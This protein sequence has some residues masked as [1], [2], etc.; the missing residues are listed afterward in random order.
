MAQTIAS[1]ENV[2]SVQDWLNIANT[3]S[4]GS[5]WAGTLY[6][7]VG[8]LFMVIFPV[9]G[10]EGGIMTAVFIGIMIGTFMLYLGII[11]PWI[12]GVLIGIEIIMIIYAVFSSPKSNYQ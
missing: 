5:F 6:L 11:S 7:I 1:W 3:N 10:V 2:T 8:V 12:L 9:A 4:G